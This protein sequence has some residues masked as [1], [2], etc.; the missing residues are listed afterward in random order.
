MIW[1]LHFESRCSVQRNVAIE[2]AFLVVI[3]VKMLQ[4]G[5]LP[6][7]SAFHSHPTHSRQPCWLCGV[8]ANLRITPVKEALLYLAG[9]SAS[10][11]L[12]KT[13]LEAAPLR[14]LPLVAPALPA[15]P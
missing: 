15:P 8:G 13:G 1:S 9:S 3:L 10:L 4:S 7:M 14:S 2:K 5:A 11:H 6:T 12:M